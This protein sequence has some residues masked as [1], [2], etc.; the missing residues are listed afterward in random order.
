MIYT[1]K[2]FSS[3]EINEWTLNSIIYTSTDQAPRK[4]FIPPRYVVEW[5]LSRHFE[6]TFNCSLVAPFTNMA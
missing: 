1:I 5:G 6:M 4:H 2:L 3:G